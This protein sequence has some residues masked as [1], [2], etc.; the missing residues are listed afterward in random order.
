LRR[1]AA[2]TITGEQLCNSV[3]GW[4][5]H[6]AGGTNRPAFDVGFTMSHGLVSQ[7]LLRLQSGG[8]LLL[9]AATA[10]EFRSPNAHGDDLGTGG[11][12]AWEASFWR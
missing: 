9:N 11:L 1:A 3:D 10:H 8:Y 2:M 4:P 6:T 7:R 12:G 5:V